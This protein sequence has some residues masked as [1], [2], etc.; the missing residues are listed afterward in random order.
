MNKSERDPKRNDTKNKH[1][2]DGS[3]CKDE[4]RKIF[5]KSSEQK[6]KEQLLRVKRSKHIYFRGK[7]C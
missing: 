4:R 3:Q 5:R 1:K 7:V 2:L 6:S